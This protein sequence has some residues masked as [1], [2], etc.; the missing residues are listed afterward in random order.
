MYLVRSKEGVKELYMNY[1]SAFISIHKS[2]E[3]TRSC[4][5]FA[6]SKGRQTPDDACYTLIVRNI[7]VHFSLR[8]V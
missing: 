7:S 1:L 8:S 4:E 5:R 3:G 2:Q 6:N